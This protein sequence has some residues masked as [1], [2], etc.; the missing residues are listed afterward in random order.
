[1]ILEA[2]GTHGKALE[3]MPKETKKLRKTRASKESVKELRVEV[4]KIKAADHLPLDLLLHE[5]PPAAQTEPEQEQEMERAPKRRMVIP[6]TDD[7]VIELECDRTYEM[8]FAHFIM[9]PH[10]EY[11]KNGNSLKIENALIDS[12]THFSIVVIKFLQTTQF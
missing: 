4:E 2:V 7:A 3:E 1:M 5:Q 9:R 12:R 6:Q 11:L 10:S 8:Q